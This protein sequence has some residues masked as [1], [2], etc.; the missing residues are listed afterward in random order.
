[1]ASS[2][3]P[4]PRASGRRWPLAE[5]RQIVELSLRVG[6]S[7]RAIA[8]DQGIRPTSPS[9][10]RT[11]YRAEKLDLAPTSPVRDPM[12]RATCSPVSI[13][14]AVRGPGLG[15]VMRPVISVERAYFRSVIEIPRASFHR[16]RYAGDRRCMIGASLLLPHVPRISS[17]IGLA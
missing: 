5:R 14:P 13:A 7:I 9:H 11:L 17:E 8:R 1:M 4:S 15:P 2:E 10:W 3:A 6:A 16:A 12:A